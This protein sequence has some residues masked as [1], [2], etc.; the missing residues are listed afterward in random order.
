MARVIFV[1]SSLPH[2]GAE[3]HAIALMNRL[4]ERGHQCHAVYI[5]A[6]GDKL[7]RIRLRDGG[8][9]RCLGAVRYLDTRALADFE[10]HLSRIRP[11]AMVAA[12]PNALMLASLARRRSGLRAPPVATSHTTPP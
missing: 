8:A 10:R 6:S 4:A 5:K 1:T 7:D 9:V 3:R 11:A 2:G 12:M